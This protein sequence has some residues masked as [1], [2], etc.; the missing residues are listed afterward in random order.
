MK[1]KRK[2]LLIVVLCI[3]LVPQL[4]K[5][6]YIYRTYKVE[7]DLEYCKEIAKEINNIGLS[8]YYCAN[9]HKAGLVE[10]SF[11]SFETCNHS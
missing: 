6:W 8:Q 3:F 9:I 11:Y 2:K 5:I 10:F 4:F 7:T 1:K